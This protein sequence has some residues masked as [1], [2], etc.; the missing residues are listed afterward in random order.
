MTVQDTAPVED[1]TRLSTAPAPPAPARRGVRLG[2]LRQAWRQLTSMRT[3]LLLLFLLALASIPGGFL[4]QR[5]QNPVEVQAYLDRHPDLGPVLDRLYL[6]DVF[7]APWFAAVYLLLFVSLVGCL[8]PRIRLHARALRTPPPA[9]PARLS[10]LPLSERWETDR[11][12]DEVRAA[13]RAALRRGR[14]RTVARPEG[15]S[16]EK[17]YLRETGN[18]VFHLSLVGLLV[19][20]AA[21]ALYGFKGS[22]LVK[23]GEGFANA[24]LS[25]DDVTPGR[26]F[27]DSALVPFNFTLEDFLATYDDQGRASE[28]QADIAWAA[29][30]DSPSAPF[31]VRVNHP[32]QVGDAKLYLIG[33]GYAPHVVVRDA[34]GEVALDQTVPC[35]PQDTNFVSTCTIKAPNA[36]PLDGSGQLGFEGVFTPT[37]ALNPDTGVTSTFPDA[38]DPGLTVGA[39]RG[40]LGTDAGLS[41]SVYELDR[42][43][44]EQVGSSPTLSPGETW[45]LP[46]G[47]SLEFVGVEEWATF[48]V[49]QDP[50]KWIALWAS[51]GIVAGLLLSLGIRRRRLWV[52]VAEVP[53]G[54]DG[55]PARTVVEVGGLA[56]TAPDA[57]EAEFAEL[58]ARLRERAAPARPGTDVP[59][60]PT[61][62]EGPRG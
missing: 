10:R 46:G 14:W 24:V 56:R 49:T 8:V 33:H 29:G 43:D 44:M 45:E 16:A 52:R 3:A 47:G 21:G 22:V 41:Q 62:E 12:A 17:G 39:F 31:R 40:N 57:F 51:V 30:P 35:L 55:T 4:P 34:D 61:H 58:T 20:V 28:F 6:F 32:L 37:T 59:H 5:G 7:A 36:G 23:E 27:D 9:L 38:T 25:Y 1:A 11:P 60:H 53:A 13:A 50:G 42:D 2:A 19:G 26:R 54:S 18:L 48:Q 15:V